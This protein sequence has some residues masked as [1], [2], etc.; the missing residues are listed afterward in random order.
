MTACCARRSC[1]AAGDFA[2]QDG[3]FLNQTLGFQEIFEWSVIDDKPVYL[4][5]RGARLGL[6]YD[7]KFLLLPYEDIPRGLCCGFASNNPMT[8][9]DTM[10]FFGKRDGT[11]YYAVVKFR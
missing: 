4:F 9:D 10:Y 11:W 1:E 2:I 7:G 3:E 5:R 6:S 8:I